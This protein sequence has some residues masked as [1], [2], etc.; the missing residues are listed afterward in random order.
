MAHMRAPRTLSGI[1][2][3]IYP[4]DSCALLVQTGVIGKRHALELRA[5]P[6]VATKQAL[7]MSNHLSTHDR[8]SRTQIDE[9][10]VPPCPSREF[11]GNVPGSG[12][13]EHLPPQN[14]QIQ[15][16]VPALCG[17]TPTA[18]NTDAHGIRDLGAQACKNLAQ[19]APMR[20]IENA[21]GTE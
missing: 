17:V 12:R 14:G 9:N 18:E 21:C 7:A 4:Q 13:C 1:P 6:F 2:A 20:I 3:A 11:L 15:V 19:Q 16:A 10:L 5:L 8:R